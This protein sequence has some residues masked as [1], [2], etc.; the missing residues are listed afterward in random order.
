MFKWYLLN[1]AELQGT[2]A[3]VNTSS[4]YGYKLKS[5][6]ADLHKVLQNMI[7]DIC[8]DTPNQA[9]CC[10]LCIEYKPNH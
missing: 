3:V 5:V 7:E 1:Q 4:C 10:D 9:G 8:I 6:L 2:W